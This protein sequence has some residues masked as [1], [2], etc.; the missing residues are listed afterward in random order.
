MKN[1]ENIEVE[2]G[3]FLNTS[4]ILYRE[5]ETINAFIHVEVAYNRIEVVLS[6]TLEF[7]QVCMLMYIHVIPLPSIHIMSASNRIV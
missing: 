2:Q 7:D 6:S 5:L 4:S 1:L 3:Q